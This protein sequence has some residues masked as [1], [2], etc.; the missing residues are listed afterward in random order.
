MTYTDQPLE[1]NVSNAFNLSQ[2]SWRQQTTQ[3][4]MTKSQPVQI[5]R[6]RRLLIC[7][8]RGSKAFTFKSKHIFLHIL[9]L[10]LDLTNRILL[11]FYYAALYH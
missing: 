1:G 3:R 9:S 2:V 6:V 8:L 10:V 11:F 7:T 4:E 5:R